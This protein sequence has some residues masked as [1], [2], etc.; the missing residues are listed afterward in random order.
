MNFRNERL[1]SELM[2]TI[3]GCHCMI[4]INALEWMRRIRVS[5]NVPDSPL[6][7]KSGCALHGYRSAP[8][9]L[10]C[11]DPKLITRF[12]TNEVTKNVITR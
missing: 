9:G 6:A 4:D 5:G 1:E 3:D 10:L 7:A 2:R 12:V 8:S 11:M